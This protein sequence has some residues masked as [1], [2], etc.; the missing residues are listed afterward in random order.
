MT[1]FEDMDFAQVTEIK[2][3]HK[4]EIIS[5]DLLSYQKRK[6]YQGCTHPVEG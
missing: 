2:Q 5:Y 3:S 1:A 4:G 6:R